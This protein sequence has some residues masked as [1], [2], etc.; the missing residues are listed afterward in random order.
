MV[1]NSTNEAG[2]TEGGP[3]NGA[4]QPN[5]ATTFVV[6]TLLA[7]APFLPPLIL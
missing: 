7:E 1:I 3:A 2:K 5:K 6:A 4:I